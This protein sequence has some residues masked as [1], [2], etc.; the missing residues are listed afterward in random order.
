TRSGLFDYHGLLEHAQQQGSASSVVLAGEQL[1]QLVV[2]PVLAPDIIGWVAMGFVMDDALAR[3]L[4][5][6][7]GLDVS[8]LA[9]AEE[10]AWRFLA[11]TIPAAAREHLT[12]ALDL[13]DAQR[14]P[15]ATFRMG[16]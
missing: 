10:Q 9:A 8:F 15:T 6:L 4:S 5:V 3:D 2:V 13:V 14:K 7:T 16:D 12:Q 1:H 11:G